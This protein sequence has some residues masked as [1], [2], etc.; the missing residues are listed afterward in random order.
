MLAC[1]ACGLRDGRNL[2]HSRSC[3]HASGAN[4]A[5]PDAH[6]DGV[7][8]GLDQCQST[9]ICGYVAGQQIHMRK[10]L[11]YLANRLQHSRRMAVRRVD[12]QH[13]Y[14]GTYQFCRPL[15]IVARGSDGSA[16]PQPAL[17]VLAGT[18]VFQFL[19]DILDRNQ[20]F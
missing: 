18:G 11:L 19:L 1:G 5:R 12:G 20:P 8:A 9:L 10:L 17:I 6:L 13:I 4:G 14:A 2:R 7:S 15:H 16:H 3:H